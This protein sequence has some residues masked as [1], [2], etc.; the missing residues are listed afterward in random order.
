[1][2]SPIGPI[3]DEAQG[4]YC[5]HVMASL[6]S[7]I[8]G[9]GSEGGAATQLPAASLG[10]IES[11]IA[12]ADTELLADWLSTPPDGLPDGRRRSA[13]HLPIVSDA[14]GVFNYGA[15]DDL[16]YFNGGTDRCSPYRSVP[17]RR[18]G[19]LPPR[20]HL[21]PLR[22]Q[23]DPRA[24]QR[25]GWRSGSAGDAVDRGGGGAAVGDQVQ[26]AAAGLGASSRC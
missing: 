26:R 4:T 3:V 25:W 19:S 10:L 1:M 11:S 16:R 21:L 7:P 8:G 5:R 22:R 18:E 17:P 2:E 6:E 9:G 15:P 23:D 14:N 13:A 20:P 12:P 24:R